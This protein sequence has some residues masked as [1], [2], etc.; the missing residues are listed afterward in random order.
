MIDESSEEEVEVVEAVVEVV[1]TDACP[2]LDRSILGVP[3]LKTLVPGDRVEVLWTHGVP[4]LFAP[5]PCLLTSHAYTHHAMLLTVPCLLTTPT[6]PCAY[7]THT[8]HATTPGDA[9]RGAQAGR[10]AESRS[11]SSRCVLMRHSMGCG[12]AARPSSST[13]SPTTTGRRCPAP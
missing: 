7:R 1:E 3:G 8:V 10:G 9:T 2:Q 5:T 4:C 12:Q 13:T 11:A 6:L